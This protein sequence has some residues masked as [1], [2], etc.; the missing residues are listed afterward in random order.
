MLTL[1]LPT[2]EPMPYFYFGR[3]KNLTSV[4]PRQPTTMPHLIMFGLLQL[5]LILNLVPTTQT[6]QPIWFMNF[7]LELQVT[8]SVR[9][10]ECRI[11]TRDLS[12][13]PQVLTQAH[14]RKLK[15]FDSNFRLEML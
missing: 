5:L 1:R 4:P 7:Q 14:L 11:L 3:R 6:V 10:V 2:T 8:L 13:P 9:S 15:K 12:I